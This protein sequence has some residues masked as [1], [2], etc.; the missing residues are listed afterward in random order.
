MA[1][2]A[3]QSQSSLSCSPSDLASRSSLTC[4]EPLEVSYGN[5]GSSKDCIARAR[6]LTLL[7]GDKQAESN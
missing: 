5:E 3:D 1:R 4:F 7:L 2:Q 6:R